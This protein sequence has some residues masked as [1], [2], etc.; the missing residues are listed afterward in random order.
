MVSSLVRIPCSHTLL[1]Y[2][3]LCILGPS[4][5]FV[6]PVQFHGIPLQ[7]LSCSHTLLL[8]IR[9]P[10]CSPELLGPGQPNSIPPSTFYLRTLGIVFNYPVFF[11]SFL[12]ISNEL[13]VLLSYGVVLHSHFI[14]LS[15][16]LRTCKERQLAKPICF[17]RFDFRILITPL[18]SSGRPLHLIVGPCIP[19]V[20]LGIPLSTSVFQRR[21]HTTVL[22]RTNPAFGNH[23]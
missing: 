6:F 11:V 2:L 17:I 12:S 3:V 1:A 5:S 18:E 21:S 8:Y 13:V 10:F 22:T 19:F 9:I 23:F 16:S 4:Y 7:F 14:L 20:F 15:R